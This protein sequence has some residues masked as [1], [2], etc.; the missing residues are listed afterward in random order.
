MDDLSLALVTN[1]VETLAM[2]RTAYWLGDT[3]VHLY[4]LVNLVA[5]ARSLLPEAVHAARDQGLT[6]TE[7]GQHRGPPPRPQPGTTD[8][9]DDP[10]DTD[11]PHNAD[12]SLLP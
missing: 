1:A 11:H 4:A 10:L 3:G 5:Q 12:E 2:L 6:W 9:T 8:P 7:I